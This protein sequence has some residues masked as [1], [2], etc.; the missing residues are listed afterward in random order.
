MTCCQFAIPFLWR[1]R[2]HFC[3]SAFVK[4]QQWIKLIDVFVL[5]LILEVLLC[6]PEAAATAPVLSP[7]V[8][9]SLTACTISVYMLGW[10]QCADIPLS[11]VTT[12]NNPVK[13]NTF[14]SI[15]MAFYCPQ[16]NKVIEV[17]YTM[18]KST[19]TCDVSVYIPS[20]ILQN[21]V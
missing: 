8:S 14:K 5:K 18:T 7:G 19:F 4:V 10:Q 15:L 13:K 16:S 9:P 17:T 1:V 3:N 20:H 12:W 2:H 11:P 21:R 6:D